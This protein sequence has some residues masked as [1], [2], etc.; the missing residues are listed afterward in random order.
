MK[1]NVIL[2]LT[3][4]GGVKFFGATLGPNLP[5][6]N[7]L[8]NFLK[9]TIHTWISGCTI[10]HFLWV[11]V[12]LKSGTII[13]IVWGY[14][15]VLLQHCLFSTSPSIITCT[16]HFC[17]FLLLWVMGF[18]KEMAISL[19]LRLQWLVQL[20]QQLLNFQV[21]HALIWK[22]IID[23]KY[24]DLFIKASGY[25]S[26]PFKTFFIFPL[27]S[28]CKKLAALQFLLIIL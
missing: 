11:Q 21:F 26:R 18:S 25:R 19:D 27:G 7:F 6:L 22:Q 3:D 5:S 9:G 24:F 13:V 2:N 15:Q 20:S 1:N 12:E 16:L 17:I 8:K 4:F 23:T 14:P 28:C 10:H